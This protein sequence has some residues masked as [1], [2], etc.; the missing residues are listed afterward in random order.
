MK[1]ILILIFKDIDVEDV[2]NVLVFI[3]FV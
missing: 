1:I 2:L 3:I